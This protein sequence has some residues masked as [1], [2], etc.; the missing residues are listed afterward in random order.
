MSPT[1]TIIAAI[2][3]LATLVFTIFGASWLHQRNIERLL[4]Q[5][6][7]RFDDRFNALEKRLDDRFAA[8]DYRFTALEQRIERIE[9]QLEAIF[10]PVL[11]K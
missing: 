2:I 11:P 1:A 5:M 3:G 8:V 9:R 6:E 4:D 10:K 7:R